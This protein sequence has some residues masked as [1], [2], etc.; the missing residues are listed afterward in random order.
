R[1]PAT[2]LYGSSAVGGVVNVLDGRIPG[3]LPEDGVKGGVQ[4]L[5]GTAANEQAA[6]AAATVGVSRLAIHAD[7]SYRDTDDLSIP[8]FAESK[9][10]RAL[11]D[12]EHD[13]E[14]ESHAFGTLPNS[15]ARTKT[16]AAGLSYVG[17]KG[18]VGICY[19]RNAQR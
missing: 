7:G 1:G 2:L 17:G 13:G 11:E 4:V 19:A 6:A 3:A 18:V 9:H 16:G 8:G 15:S 10:L 12:E 14:E 5:Y